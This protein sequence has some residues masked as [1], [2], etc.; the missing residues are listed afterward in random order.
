MQLKEVLNYIPVCFKT[1]LNGVKSGFF[2]SPIYTENNYLRYRR[3]DIK[4]FIKNYNTVKLLRLSDVSKMVG[5]S[6]KNLY[7]ELT[8]R[9][10]PQPLKIG[11]RIIVWRIED[12]ENYIKELSKES[13]KSEKIIMSVEEVIKYVENCNLKEVTEIVKFCNQKIREKCAGSLINK[14]LNDA[15]E[16]AFNQPYTGIIHPDDVFNQLK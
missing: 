10:F 11:E 7:K 5:I 9:T 4:E 6:K 2:P 16:E 3:K 13:E 15:F 14:T 12:I 1:W 8:R